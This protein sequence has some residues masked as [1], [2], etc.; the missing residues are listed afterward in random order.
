MSS[1][2]AENGEQ[3][4]NMLRTGN[5]D[6]VLLDILMP[7]MDGYEVLE[8]MQADTNLR[9]IPVIVISALEEEQSA[10]RCIEMGAEDYLNKNFNPVFLRARISSSLRRKKLRDL[11]QAYLKARVNAATERKIGHAWAFEC[12][13]G[14]RTE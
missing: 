1:T 8:A 4:L 5:Y 14:S 11:E 13:H 9:R 2:P 7:V 6:V 12:W 10:V 3:A